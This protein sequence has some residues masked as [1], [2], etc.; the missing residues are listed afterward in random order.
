MPC[1]KLRTP[2]HGA[3]SCDTWAYGRY[4]SMSC[5]DNYDIPAPSPFQPATDVF[6]CGSSGQWKPTSYVPDCSRKFRVGYQQI[7]QGGGGSF[8]SFKVSRYGQAYVDK[9]MGEILSKC[10]RKCI[11]MSIFLTIDRMLKLQWYFPS[12]DLNL[13]SV[14]GGG[15]G[16]P[17]S[18][19][20]WFAT[21]RDKT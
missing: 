9:K 12:C 10:R 19:Y 8:F 20:P 11:C 2:G 1:L 21:I 3:I 15:G 14:V 18:L 4:C 13:V 5:N 16:T 7:H 6:T 17:A